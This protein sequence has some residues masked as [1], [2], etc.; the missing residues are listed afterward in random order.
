M[1]RIIPVLDVMGGQVVRAI[2]GR[3]DEYRPLVSPLCGSSEPVAVASALLATTGATEL[4]VAD[5]DAIRGHPALELNVEVLR[6]LVTL[7]SHVWA[8]A[9]IRDLFDECWLLGAGVTS[10]VVGTETTNGDDPV[11]TLPHIYG[12]DRV[13]LSI[14]FHAGR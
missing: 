8:D 11:A 5:L 1:A 14:D 9:G 3:R 7:G 12:G 13:A 10:F 2:G 4:Y 6:R